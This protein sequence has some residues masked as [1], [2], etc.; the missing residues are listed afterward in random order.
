M[1]D[2]DAAAVALPPVLVW[3]VNTPANDPRTVRVTEGVELAAAT[4]LIA[5]GA[6]ATAGIMFT[7]T[8]ADAATALGALAYTP[9]GV[10]ESATF[11]V[12]DAEWRPLSSPSPAAS[13]PTS[14]TSASST[15]PANTPIA[16]EPPPT[17][18]TTLFGSRPVRSSSCARASRP[19]AAWNSRTIRG[20][21]AGPT[22]EPMM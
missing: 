20:Y 13:T 22:T 15:K 5:L 12:S 19:I 4:G 6:R 8:A 3:D 11:A 9:G 14:S 10:S 1:V 21:G 7:A 18:A 17:H 2:E 16:F